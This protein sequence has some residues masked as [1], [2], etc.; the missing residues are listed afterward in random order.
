M[1]C[2]KTCQC[3]SQLTAT[4]QPVLFLLQDKYYVKVD[5]TAIEVDSAACFYDAVEFLL[6]IFYVFHLSYEYELKP[7]FGFIEKVMKLPVTTG[8]TSA[9]CDLWRAVSRRPD[10]D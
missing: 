1:L 10:S 9:V 4:K 5:L 2:R 7:T 6:S 3:L 8:R